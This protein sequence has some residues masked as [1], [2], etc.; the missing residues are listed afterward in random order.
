MNFITT[1]TFSAQK[2]S[3]LLCFGPLS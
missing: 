3:H 1:K 2:G